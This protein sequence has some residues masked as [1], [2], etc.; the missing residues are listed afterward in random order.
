MRF[1]GGRGSRRAAL[2]I[3][4]GTVFAAQQELRPPRSFFSALPIRLPE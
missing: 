1:M 4:A 2:Q 3:E